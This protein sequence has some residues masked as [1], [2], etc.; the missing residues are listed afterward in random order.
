[1]FFPGSNWLHRIGRLVVLAGFTLTA[2][3]QV[4]FVGTQV[5]VASQ[6]LAG[7]MGLSADGLG[8]VYIADTG[9]GRIVSIAVSGAGAAQPVTVISGLSN[10]QGVAAD[11]YG[12][13][14]VAETGNNRVLKFALSQGAYGPPTV[15][16]SG[17]SSPGGVAVDQAGNV[18]VA[19]SGNNRILEAPNL[20]SAYGAPQVLSSIFNNP[21]GVAVDAAMNVFVADT[22]N[23]RVVKLPISHGVYGAPVIVSRG[24]VNA[25]AIA[26]DKSDNLYVTDAV[27]HQVLRY[28]WFAAV[29]YYYP[30]SA[31]GGDF[32]RAEGVA[33]SPQGQVYIADVMKN[34]VITLETASVNFPAIPVGA[35]ASPMQFDFNIAAG[36]T[37]GPVAIFSNGVA[38]GEFADVGDSTCAAQTFSTA[39]L[40]VVDIVFTPVASGLRNG[41]IVL[42]DAN[43]NILATAY[44][45]GIGIE[46][47]AAF[48][49]GNATP[50]V[51]QLS[52]P[53]GVAVD[54]LG[55][56]YIADT[57][58]DRVVELPWNGAGYGPQTTLPL[59]NVS[60][61]MG[62]AIDGAGNLLIASSGIDRV[63]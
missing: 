2:S 9:N 59:S 21:M 62:L 60:S 22:G 43:G 8:N 31:I 58:N 7:P 56:L 4:S 57:G 20:G 27:H 49:P 61:P 33:L 12:N 23:N 14:Y 38:T 52:G 37:L 15:V 44:I 63:I 41:A 45:S 54:G 46:P 55:N 36:T 24:V 6:G 26:V 18:Y 30:S 29:G 11:W 34:E 1:M 40:C 17:L 13:L 47:Q 19:D 50:L 39:A 10:P 16:C 42:S 35:P 3:A 51:T 28:P 25:T 5:I 32:P 48:Y 53:S